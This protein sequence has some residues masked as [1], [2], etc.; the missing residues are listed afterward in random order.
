MYNV[1]QYDRVVNTGD[2][3][4]DATLAGLFVGTNSQLCQD[5]AEIVAYGFATLSTSPL[6]HTCGAVDATNLRAYTA[7]QI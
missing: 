4:F 3:Q 5:S 1:V 2:G 6:G 7:A